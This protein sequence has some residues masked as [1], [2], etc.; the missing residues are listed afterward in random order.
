[1]DASPWP[2][3]PEVVPTA[4]CRVDP[5]KANC[6][7]FSRVLWDNTVASAKLDPPNPTEQRLWVLPGRE[8]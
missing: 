1:M 6:V 4:P 7:F 3:I 2:C 5:M 8:P